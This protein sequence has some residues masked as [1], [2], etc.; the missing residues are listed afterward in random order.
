MDR[1]WQKVRK[2]FHYPQLP[3]P[4]LIDSDK[5]AGINMKS[6]EVNVSEPFIKG[7]E[8]QGISSEESLNEIISA[9]RSIEH[10]VNIAKTKE[11]VVRMFPLNFDNFRWGKTNDEPSRVFARKIWQQAWK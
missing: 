9:F 7:F 5:T 1:E 4:R 3:H 11:D 8:N 6:L 10:I 2:N